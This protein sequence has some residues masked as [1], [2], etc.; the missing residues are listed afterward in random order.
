MGGMPL[1]KGWESVKVLLREVWVLLFFSCYFHLYWESKDGVESSTVKLK[2]V[3]D[4]E[5]KM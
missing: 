3:Y 4:S 2:D 1:A 5:K